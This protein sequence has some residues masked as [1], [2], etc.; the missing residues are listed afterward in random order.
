[1]T[2]VK[3][4]VSDADGTLVNTIYLI[5]HGQY[6]TV[7]SYLVQ[8]GISDDHIPTYEQFEQHL[9]TALGGSARETLER[10]VR[11]IFDDMQDKLEGMDF[12]ILHDLL[13]PIQD[14]IAPE[15]VTAYPGLSQFLHFLGRKGIDLAVFT[16][17]TPHHVVRNFGLALPELGL[18]HLFTDTRHSSLEK[19]N[20]FEKKVETLFNI[21]SMIFVTCDDV[22]ANKPDPESLLQALDRLNVAKD[23][24]LVLGD[25]WVDMQA[26]VNAGIPLRVGIAHGFDSESELRKH[27][28][29]SVVHNYNELISQIQTY[30]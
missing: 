17:G 22:T 7:K 16:S 10:T 12:D 26:G 19:M 6:E 4:V 2:K 20:Q 8:H 15:Y 5:R 1:M 18:T 27:G 28:A 24:A 9:H 13:D 3:A 23:E 25:H 29:T 14:R 30:E 21:P 11:L